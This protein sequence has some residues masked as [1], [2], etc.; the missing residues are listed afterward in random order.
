MINLKNVISYHAREYLDS[1][2]NELI[3]MILLNLV[4]CRCVEHLVYLQSFQHKIS[5]Y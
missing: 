5:N 4:C 3:S 2:E 1:L